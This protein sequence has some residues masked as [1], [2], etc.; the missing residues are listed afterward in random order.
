[1]FEHYQKNS[2]QRT[3]S[4]FKHDL[5]R[6]DQ[7]DDYKLP[8]GMYLGLHSHV[9]SFALPETPHWAACRNR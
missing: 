4:L 3:V 6:A 7:C 2:L 9:C 1:M 8:I 5:A